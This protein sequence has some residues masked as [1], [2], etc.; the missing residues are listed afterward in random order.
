[1]A[2]GALVVVERQPHTGKVNLLIR[3]GD[4][5]D[6]LGGE[7]EGGSDCPRTG[8]VANSN[9]GIVPPLQGEAGGVTAWC[10]GGHVSLLRVFSSLHR[11]I[12]RTPTR[13]PRC[14]ERASAIPSTVAGASRSPR[15]SSN[16]GRV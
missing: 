13:T 12:V 2:D 4:D 6:D 11:M 14:S 8:G 7:V 1:M 9:S 16:S 15:T 5:L 10:D 3:V